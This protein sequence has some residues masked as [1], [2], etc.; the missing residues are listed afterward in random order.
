MDVDYCNNHPDSV[1]AVVAAYETEGALGELLVGAGQEEGKRR[2][3]NAR[4]V[5]VLHSP[6]VL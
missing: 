6:A 2:G 1:D 5:R 4:L 3:S